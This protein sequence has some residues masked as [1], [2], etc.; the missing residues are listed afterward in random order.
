[1]TFE[2]DIGLTSLTG[3]KDVNEDFAAAMR[4]EPGQAAVGAI[5]AIA[6]GVSTGLFRHTR[7]LEH[8]GGAR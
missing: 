5:V 3:R 8:H 6:D 1:M 4:A 2:I 7:D